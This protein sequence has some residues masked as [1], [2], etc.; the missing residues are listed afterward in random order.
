MATERQ[1]HRK[2]RPSEDMDLMG[3]MMVATVRAQHRAVADPRPKD[4]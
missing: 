4:L 1:A 3:Q 2:V